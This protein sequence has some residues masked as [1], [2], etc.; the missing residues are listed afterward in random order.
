MAVTQFGIVYSTGNLQV[1]R[2]LFLDDDSHFNDPSIL[3][4]GESLQL[5]STGSTYSN[6]AS[7][8]STILEQGIPPDQWTIQQ[9]STLS[10]ILGKPLGDPYCPVVNTLGQVID[11]IMADPVIDV[12]HADTTATLISDPTH[13]V[14]IGWTWNQLS[15][16]IAPPPLPTNTT[17]TL[18][19]PP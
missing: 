8:L 14:G 1:R 10:S 11:V 19:T 7:Y 4:P 18:L 16:F 3:L 2:W 13:T 6:A 17:H 9:Q 12:Y 5:I 15:G